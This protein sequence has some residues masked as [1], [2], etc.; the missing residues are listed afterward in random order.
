LHE[1]T[2]IIACCSYRCSYYVFHASFTEG[3]KCMLPKRRFWKGGGGGRGGG[4]RWDADFRSTFQGLFLSTFFMRLLPRAVPGWKCDVF[5]RI[6]A[7]ISS[8]S[9]ASIKL[10]NFRPHLRKAVEYVVST[11][12]WANVYTKSTNLAWY[13]RMCEK[14]PKCEY[15]HHAQ[16]CSLSGAW[17]CAI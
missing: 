4:K 3:W 12:I 8:Y 17:N 16:L 1:I 9:E 7:L 14:C 15:S 11:H 5:A 6:Y 2:Q 10:R 13:M